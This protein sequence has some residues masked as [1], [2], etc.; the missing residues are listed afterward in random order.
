M[1]QRKSISFSASSPESRPLWN[2]QSEFLADSKQAQIKGWDWVLRGLF[3]ICSVVEQR[4][5]SSRW[6]LNST[7]LLLFFIPF[8]ERTMGRKYSLI[9]SRPSIPYMSSLCVCKCVHLELSKL[10]SLSSYSVITGCWR[11]T[12]CIYFLWR[13]ELKEAWPRLISGQSGITISIFTTK[14]WHFTMQDVE[15]QC[16]EA[17]R[18]TITVKRTWWE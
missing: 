17:K 12:S 7:F 15:N 2:Y 8:L 18:F 1:A 4:W 13:I 9:H 11:R 16:E 3:V 6:L 10:T 5:Q 14:T